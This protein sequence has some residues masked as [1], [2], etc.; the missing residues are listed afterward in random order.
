VRASDF[1]NAIDGCLTRVLGALD[2]AYFL[3]YVFRCASPSLL[4]MLYVSTFFFPRYTSDDVIAQ[5]ISMRCQMLHLLVGDAVVHLMTYETIFGFQFDDL[6]GKC[7]R[8]G[9]ALGLL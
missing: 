1:V 6:T 8:S 4:S 9:P 3:Y 5:W 2:R 7:F